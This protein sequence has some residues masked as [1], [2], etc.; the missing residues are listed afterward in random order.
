MVITSDLNVKKVQKNI[1]NKANN[2]DVA[3]VVNNAHVF[4]AFVKEN[5]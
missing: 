5:V 4:E 1:L 3:Q 2:H